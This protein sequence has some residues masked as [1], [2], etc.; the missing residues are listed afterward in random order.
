ML[1][2]EG[3]RTYLVAFQNNAEVRA[4]GGMPGSMVELTARDGRLKMG[5]SFTPSDLAD[6]T[7]VLPAR[8]YELSSSSR[9]TS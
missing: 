9:G 8:A 4:T 5:R 6:G 1:G 3:E 2:E 7:R